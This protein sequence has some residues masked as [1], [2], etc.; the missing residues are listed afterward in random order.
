LEGW[1]VQIG[2][3]DSIDDT[4]VQADQEGT[5][6]LTL[7]RGLAGRLRGC[8]EPQIEEV[9]RRQSYFRHHLAQGWVVALFLLQIFPGI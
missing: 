7:R 8:E 2:G 6:R 5:C 9:R 4:E 1:L 3:A